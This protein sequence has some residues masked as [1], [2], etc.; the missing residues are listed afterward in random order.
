MGDI[1]FAYP[2]VLWGLLLIPTL[3]VWY[4]YQN[5]KQLADIRFVHTKYYSATIKSFR[6]HLIHLPII[7]R[8]V[9][10]ALLITTMARPQTKSVLS[11]T[12]LEGVEIMIALDISGSMLAEDFQPNRME[13]A[14]LTAIDF[15]SSRPDD[16]IGVTVFSGQSFTLS[17]LTTDHALVKE[18]ISQATTGMVADGTAI[19]DGLATAVN[20]LRE[21][22]ALSRV[23][24]LLTDGINNTGVIDPLTAAEIAAMYGVRVYTIGVGSS[25]PVPYPFQTPF[26]VQYQDVEIPVDE[27]LL[28][29]IAAMTGGRYFWAEDKQTLESIYEEI[30]QLER[31]IIDIQEFTR[32][33]DEYI[34]LVLLALFFLGVESFLRYTWLRTVP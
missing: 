4:I 16:R 8:M 11:Q 31:S 18:L 32:V 26:G 24:V 7:L 15:V 22:T 33:K 34:I 6:Q 12:S 19:G 25:G 1:I 17:P 5:K 13:A 27:E 21:S 3:V 30:D 9:T 14:K 29:E 23:V 20:R 10:L 28:Q 2:Y